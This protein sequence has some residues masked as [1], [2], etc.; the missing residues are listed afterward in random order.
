MYLAKLGYSVH[1][2]VAMTRGL[3]ADL[4]AFT[5]DLS[6]CLV[7]LKSCAQDW[8]TDTKWGGYLP[9]AHRCYV[10]VPHTI[11]DNMIMQISSAVKA[12]GAGLLVLEPSGRVRVRVRSVVRPS[13][14][15][16]HI[17]ATVIKL[18][19]RQGAHRGNTRRVKVLLP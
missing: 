19:W 15:R 11:G 16:G 1:H 12:V 6:T 7:E 14:P 5:T 9:F 18:A 8:T 2:E 4:W 10:A 13:L 17:K 3:R